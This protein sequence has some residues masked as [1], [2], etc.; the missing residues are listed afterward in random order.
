MR[1][2]KQTLVCSRTVHSSNVSINT[3]QTMRIIT[4]ILFLFL[5]G[6]KSE[7]PDKSVHDIWDSYTG[8][9]SKSGNIEMPDYWHFHNN[10]ED[11]NRLAGLIVTGKKKAMSEPYYWY[12]SDDTEMDEIGAKHIIIDFDGKAQ[13]IIEIKRI[14]TIPFNQISK[15]FAAL[16]MGTDIE[17]LKK[18]KKAH[19]DFFLTAMKQDGKKPTEEMLIVCEWFETI[20][21]KNSTNANNGYIK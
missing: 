7:K 18:W 9:N 6:C 12:E 13:A 19:W 15:D 4:T 11:A 1:G 14:D 8:A 21:T 10:R 20:W 16:D 3:Q 17:P 5:I 2:G